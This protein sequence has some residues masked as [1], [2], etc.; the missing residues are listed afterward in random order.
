MVHLK[1]VI[2][3]EYVQSMWL[4][5]KVMEKRILGPVWIIL[6]FL[7]VFEQFLLNKN[8]TLI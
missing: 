5:V 6:S 1:Y 7:S 3:N 8:G 2:I 4:V